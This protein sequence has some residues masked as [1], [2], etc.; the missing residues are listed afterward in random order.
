MK[1]FIPCTKLILGVFPVSSY[2]ACTPNQFLKMFRLF[3]QIWKFQKY[4]A[5]IYDFKSAL[6]F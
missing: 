4:S 5:C 2:E 3:V 1:N 6:Q